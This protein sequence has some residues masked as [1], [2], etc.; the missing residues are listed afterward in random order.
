MKET[1]GD[2]KFHF[3]EDF[4]EDS[5]ANSKSNNN[6]NSSSSSNNNANL[7]SLPSN[8]SNTLAPSLLG[9]FGTPSPPVSMGQAQS[10][11]PTSNSS[12]MNSNSNNSGLL[13]G[14]LGQPTM[15]IPQT[16]QPTM[17][18]PQNQQQAST[19][20]QLPS[21]S[22][23]P[24]SP[25]SVSNSTPNLSPQQPMM[26]I[27]TT[28]PI[29]SPAILSPTTL[30]PTA[31]LSPH[32]AT[33]PQQ[34]IASSPSTTSPSKLM[35]PISV[36]V[37]ST[38]ISSSAWSDDDSWGE[39]DFAAANALKGRK[40][41]NAKPPFDLCAVKTI[42]DVKKV[43]VTPSTFDDDDWSAEEQP[44]TLVYHTHVPSDGKGK[45]ESAPSQTTMSYSPAAKL[46]GGVLVANG[47]KPEADDDD[48]GDDF[49]FETS[50]KKQQAMTNAGGNSVLT[51]S[52]PIPVLSPVASHSFSSPMLMSP[53]LQSPTFISL[54]PSP[55][56]TLQPTLATGDSNASFSQSTI[57][58]PTSA[59]TPTTTAPST[60]THATIR[61]TMQPSPM[62]L[63]FVF[64]SLTQPSTPIT[65]LSPVLVPSPLSATLLSQT[66]PSGEA[67][68]PSAFPLQQLRRDSASHVQAQPSPVLIGQAT[69]PPTAPTLEFASTATMTSPLHFQSPTAVSMH[70][71]VLQPSPMQAGTLP[72]AL[73][74][75][76]SPLPSTAVFQSPLIA[77]QPTS[78]PALMST[79]PSFDPAPLQPVNSI[80][81]QPISTTQDSFS[82]QNLSAESFLQPSAS[83]HQQPLP[84][85]F[86][87]LT[88]YQAPLQSASLS[89]SNEPLFSANDNTSANSL[90]FNAQADTPSLFPTES[91][92]SFLPMSLQAQT[93]EPKFEPLIS[94][95]INS[96]PIAF[97]G[98]PSSQ[99]DD[100][101]DWGAVF[102][103]AQQRS[104]ALQS[105]IATPVAFSPPSTM[106][107]SAADG[108]DDWEEFS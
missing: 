49:V 43:S 74:F 11:F 17:L 40:P 108:G 21:Y 81:L 92:S 2:F 32:N 80:T 18:I 99:Q 47:G 97:P 82:S 35:N 94:S 54:Q 37:S 107:S 29:L 105:P 86:E 36:E 104:S 57:L 7:L 19:P 72:S 9:G 87:R 91:A 60:P 16:Q 42:L 44:A 84:M 23:Q 27:P 25:N 85:G 59:L 41:S 98:T 83:I 77:F 68:S 69:L 45:G 55:M 100:D 31:V 51:H 14:L 30:S 53:Q 52:T 39:A 56:Q 38:K 93:V 15:L 20:T 46:S 48:W 64:D 103:S 58:S 75:P 33:S 102:P 67:S 63:Q 62:P 8:N 13:G 76:S 61:P 6:N 4:P 95:S 101:D 28:T 89:S 3:P 90:A 70:S 88:P 12:A 5:R 24:I 73:E 26:L 106:Q 22:L 10:L 34:S 50:K 65:P 1:V 71:P 78:S 66:T 79:I 96:A